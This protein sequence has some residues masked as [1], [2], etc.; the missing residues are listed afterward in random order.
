MR[1]LL[2]LL[3]VASAA[4][5]QID[6]KT[7]AYEIKVRYP[8][9]P[10]VEAWARKQ[11]AD[12]KKDLQGATGGKPDRVPWNL[13]ISYSEPWKNKNVQAVYCVG[14]SYEGGAHPA[15]FLASFVVDIKSGKALQLSDLF[16]GD[17]L[18][19]FAAYARGELAK[20]DISSEPDRIACGTKP[21][22]ENYSVAYPTQ[23][24]HIL[25]FAPYRFE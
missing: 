8:K 11:V 4:L 24:C 5:A 21:M 18:Q 17:Y 19:A 2:L 22:A 16:Q 6:E 1:V 23:Q 13:E 3:L 15:P 12:F 10:V 20:R 9:V 14:S 7:T 25:V